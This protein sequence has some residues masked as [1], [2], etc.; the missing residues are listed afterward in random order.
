MTQPYFRY[1]PLRTPDSVR[2]LHLQPAQD[3]SSTVHVRFSEVRLPAASQTLRSSPRY[4][5]L[6]YTWGDV[7]N[8]QSI[9]SDTGDL[10]VTRNLFEALIHLRHTE[11]I[12]TLWVDAVCINQDEVLERDAQVRL[13][14]RIY[15]RAD[16]VIVWLGPSANSSDI[17]PPLVERLVSLW[18]ERDQDETRIITQDEIERHHIPPRDAPVWSAFIALLR[19]PW[20][21]RVW[22]IQEVALSQRARVVCGHVEM[23]WDE[24]AVAATLMA[25]AQIFDTTRLA[26][27]DGI[28]TISSA[29]IQCRDGEQ[30]DLMFQISHTRSYQAT[31]PRDKVFAL[32][33]IVDDEDRA[34]IEVD[35]SIDATTLYVDVAWYIIQSTETL[36][37]LEHAGFGKKLQNLPSWVPDWSL[38]LPENYMSLVDVCHSAYWLEVTKYGPVVTDVDERTC[39]CVDGMR[40]DVIDEVSCALEGEAVAIENLSQECR[41]RRFAHVFDQWENLALTINEHRYP[42]DVYGDGV[43]NAY[44]KTLIA[45]ATAE[46]EEV[47]LE[48][49]RYFVDWYRKYRAGG[50]MDMSQVTT[51][52][53]SLTSEEGATT[54]SGCVFDV[55]FGRRF[56]KTKD[57][58]MGMFPRD[59][60]RADLV[61]I[62]FGSRFP[63]VLREVNGGWAFLG[64]CYVHGIWPND[65]VEGPTKAQRTE[66]F[67]L[68]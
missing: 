4:E 39:L 17:V 52:D 32:L 31:D 15:S 57:R 9:T 10:L 14:G 7:R 59:T 21:T 46:N 68:C 19:R 37:I 33:S 62:L 47:D 44:W 26:G 50:K 40:I 54:Y 13:M 22:V 16:L 3:A 27:T 6:S 34:A 63:V 25:Q 23:D 43:T 1:R 67:R 20:T 30:F 18:D 5:A 8:R 38:T 45:G 66:R 55:G 12:R 2:L 24:L 60:K 65:F 36:D 29:K 61:I 42:E 35:Y 41:E 58:Y 53:S 28:P 56:G 49:G 11:E 48:Y 51:K 64:V